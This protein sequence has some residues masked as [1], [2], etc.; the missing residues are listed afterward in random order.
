MS[1][2][3]VCESGGAVLLILEIQV[4]GKGYCALNASCFSGCAVA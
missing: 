1:K 4:R 2:L 3:A